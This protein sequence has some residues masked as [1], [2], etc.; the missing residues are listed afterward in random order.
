MSE[1]PEPSVA[2]SPSSAPSPERA[3]WGLWFRLCAVATVPLLLLAATGVLLTRSLAIGGLDLSAPAFQLYVLG[4][5]LLAAVLGILLATWLHLAL[6]SRL[7][8]LHRALAEERSG[9]IRGLELEGGWDLL[10]DV[11][12]QASEL[13]SRS[14]EAK[15]DARVLAE[16]REH[17]DALVAGLE[18]WAATESYRDLAFDPRLGLLGAALETLRVRLEERDTEA[19]GATTQTLETA[20]EARA[21]VE[22]AVREAKKSALEASLLRKDLAVLRLELATVAPADASSGAAAGRGGAVPSRGEWVD[23]RR[24]VAGLRGR[25]E[26]EERRALSLALVLAAARLKS[27]GSEL[28]GAGAR[29]EAE[30]PAAGEAMLASLAATLTVAAGGL[31]EIA[32]ACRSLGDEVRLFDA[33]LVAWTKPLEEAGP[34]P[35][36]AAGSLSPPA[37][38]EPLRARLAVLEQ[39]GERLVALCER[40]ERHAAQAVLGVRAAE[41]DLGGLVSRFEPAP[42]V[43]NPGGAGD[44][45]GDPSRRRTGPLRLL[46]RDD[47]LADDED[48]SPG[49]SSEESRETSPGSTGNPSGEARGDV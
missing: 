42:P 22:L 14:H 43:E 21:A 5:L 24:M 4:A 45:A 30:H 9:E 12:R 38:E 35:S 34:A 16:L 39:R 28:G 6:R 40:A 27:R 49:G 18:E 29:P 11:A 13:L 36:G 7:L 25:L 20:Q 44:A 19:H 15:S 41:D 10:S 23:A 26:E 32:L 46:T 2:D 47:V 1:S 3:G 31:R 17:L 33:K 8:A 37:A 48:P